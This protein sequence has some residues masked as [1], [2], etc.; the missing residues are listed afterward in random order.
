MSRPTCSQIFI[1]TNGDITATELVGDMLVGSII[2]TDGDV[3]LHSPSRILDADGRPTIDVAGSEHHDVRRRG[4][5]S[6]AS[7]G[8]GRSRRDFLEVDTATAT[9]PAPPTAS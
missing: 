5:S 7:V 1:R 3:E 8:I 2:S 9:R 4:G 6:A